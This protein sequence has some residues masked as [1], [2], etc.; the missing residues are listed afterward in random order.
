MLNE[1]RKIIK[2][3]LKNDDYISSIVG[4]R[5][6]TKKIKNVKRQKTPFIIVSTPS[7][8]RINQHFENPKVV[9]ECYSE[10][11]DYLDKLYKPY[12]NSEEGIRYLLEY[13]SGIGSKYISIVT[14]K[15]VERLDDVD[16]NTNWDRMILV[17][18]LRTNT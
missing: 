11:G 17:F 3:K 9:I 15:F 7:D 4:D 1:I 12:D 2:E 18:T 6:Y 8:T 13:G 5:V 10:G 14:C 16:E